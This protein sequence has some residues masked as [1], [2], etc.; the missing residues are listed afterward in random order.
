MN[1]EAIKFIGVCLL[2]ATS[3][4]FIVIFIRAYENTSKINCININKVG[5]AKFEMFV[6]VP[7]V[8]ASGV[9]SFVLSIKD[10]NK[11]RE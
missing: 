8:L 4:T 6:L 5:E 7:L 10:L 1:T 3:I 9:T 2:L 11:E